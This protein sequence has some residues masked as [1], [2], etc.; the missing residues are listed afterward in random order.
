M[1]R[2]DKIHKK[3]KTEKMAMEIMNSPRYREARK[4][5]MQEAT[6]NALATFTFIGLVYLEMNFGCKQKG[7]AKFLEFV[8]GT[9]IDFRD[10]DKWLEASDGY[11]KETYGMNVLDTLGMEPRKVEGHGKGR[12]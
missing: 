11:F 12:T 2:L 7:L 3:I 9:V 4:H 5:D 6:M 10:D 1:S 8:K